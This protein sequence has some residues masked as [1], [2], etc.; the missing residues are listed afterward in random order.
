MIHSADRVS[1]FFHWPHTDKDGEADKL[2]HAALNQAC[3]RPLH[4]GAHGCT[5]VTRGGVQCVLR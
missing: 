1:G 2:F 5:V 4:V 3:C